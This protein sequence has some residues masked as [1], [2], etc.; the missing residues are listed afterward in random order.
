MKSRQVFSLLDSLPH[1]QIMVQVIKSFISS[2]SVSVNKSIKRISGFGLSA[3][4]VCSVSQGFI[5]SIRQSTVEIS[6]YLCIIL[7]A[8]IQI[9]YNIRSQPI[10]STWN[11]IPVIKMGSRVVNCLTITPHDYQIR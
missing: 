7:W 10:H 5:L 9:I 2:V 1:N 3:T 11:S 8:G 6:S 4:Y